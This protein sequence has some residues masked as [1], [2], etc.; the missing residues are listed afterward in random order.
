MITSTLCLCAAL[1]LAPPGSSAKKAG[2]GRG[3]PPASYY[4]PAPPPGLNDGTVKVR[5]DGLPVGKVP[6]RRQALVAMMPLTSLGSTEEAAQSVERVLV[7]E[8]QRLIGDKLVPPTEVPDRIGPAGAQALAACDGVL[9][10]LIELFGAL[11]WQT[12]LVG[13]IAG[14]GDDRVINIKTLDLLTGAVKARASESAAGDETLLVRRMRAAAVRVLAPERYL[15]TIEVAAKQPGVRILLDG[16][17]V[18]TVPLASP[19]F[20]VTVG[21][22]AIEANGPG[23]VPFSG[24]VEVG[25]D[26]VQKVTVLLPGNTVFVGGDVPFYATWWT[27]ALAGTGLIA[28]GIGGYFNYEHV[29][30]IDRLN[31]RAQACQAGGA[32]ALTADS[33]TLYTDSQA[34]WTRALIFYGAG[35]TLLG[36]VGIMWV[37]DL[38]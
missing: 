22:H 21:R 8:V 11:G 13:N 6:L 5:L 1:V 27:W 10:C 14:L 18:G 34:N 9:D 32:C 3:A 30:A 37:T 38:F 28:S 15:G 20:S 7:A 31:S 4:P 29:R 24:F 19:R 26:D 35:G 23:L 36:G 17:L 16:N 33:A 2:K 12:L 25:Y